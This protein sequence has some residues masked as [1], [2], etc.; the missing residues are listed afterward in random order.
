MTVT[1]TPLSA[2]F[3]V[4]VHGLDLT[5]PVVPDDRARLRHLF[6][7][8]HL[9][10]FRGRPVSPEEQLALC[11][12]LGPVADPVAWVSNVEPG[13]HPEGELLFHSDY[14]FTGTPM[15]GLSLYAAEL[16]PGAAPTRFASGVHAYHTL[17]P[18]QRAVVDAIEVVHLI[19]AVSGRENV[20]TR[21][22]DVGGDD[23][24]HD[25]YPRHAG[26][27]VV[28]HPTT[29]DAVLAVLEQQA[30]HVV[31]WGPE[32]GEALL[33]QLFT[34]LYRP[35]VVY[36]HTWQEH[37]LVVWD[38]VALQHGRRANPRAVR[39]SL[40]RVAIHDVP[41]A[42]LIAGTGFDPEWR[43]RHLTG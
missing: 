37:D 6:A 5:G 12:I 10:L 23:A 39:R 25:R 41:T 1:A 32:E 3:G 31:G 35:D 38:N 43:R 22:A 24:P 40:R 8:R 4:Q 30:S 14:V 29:G 7:T 21:L 2:A 15:L 26:P 17:T 20:R 42:E 11:E 19:D 9:L 28:R 16:G 34:H 27:A 18:S 13:F 36:E 33:Q